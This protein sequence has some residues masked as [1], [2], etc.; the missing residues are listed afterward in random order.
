MYFQTE[1]RDQ[2][3]ILLSLSAYLYAFKYA[4]SDDYL[5]TLSDIGSHYCK[6]VTKRLRTYL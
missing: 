1:N 4:F 5:G 3:R 6:Q 2:V